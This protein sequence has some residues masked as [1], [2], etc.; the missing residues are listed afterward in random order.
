MKI[1]FRL[2]TA[3]TFLLIGACTNNAP[4]RDNAD[5]L[6]IPADAVLPDGGRYQGQILNGKFNGHGSIVWPNGEAYEGEFLNGQFSGKGRLIDASGAKYEGEFQRGVI[7]GSG[8]LEMKEGAIYSGQFKDNL[9]HGRGSLQFAADH[10][11]EGEFQNNLYHGK[12]ILVNPNVESY[13][14][15][16]KEGKY[17]GYGSVKYHNGDSYQGEFR[18]NLRQ[19][20][21][22]YRIA[23]G[24]IFEGDFKL[25]EF[26]GNGSFTDQ[27]GNHYPGNFQN[28]VFH[29][30]GIYTTVDGGI[31]E[32]DFKEGILTGQGTFK[33]TNGMVYEGEFDS[34]I[35][36][37]KGTLIKPNGDRYSGEFYGGM[38]HGIGEL[39][40]KS[41]K[42][43]VVRQIGEWRYNRFVPEENAIRK[44]I[45]E[46]VE[47]ALY[48]QYDLMQW[49]LSSLKPQRPQEIDLFFIG[50]A[51]YSDQE[52][53]EK[54]IDF[55]KRQF[56]TR[57]NT[58]GHSVALVNSISLE[59]KFPLATL[60]SIETTLKSVSEKM[61]PDNDILFLY[62]TS[63]GSKDHEFS[64]QQQG[65]ELAD[66]PA[67][68]LADMLAALPIKWKVV[69]VSACY[70]G[71][72]IAEIKDQYT[73]IMTAASH[74]RQSFGCSD[75]SDMTYF[76]RAYFEKSLPTA[77]SFTAAFD[78]AKE[79][80]SEWEKD[81]DSQSNPQIVAPQPIVA[82]LK[83]WRQQFGGNR[84][85][86]QMK[87]SN[88]P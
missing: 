25:G 67:N 76:G 72:V 21:G 77:E 45:A 56:D 48:H 7:S 74:D 64:I 8:V 66:L 19:G 37:G 6:M 80:I 57:Y 27:E 71:G 4:L 34:W 44:K 16:F 88:N 52:V 9:F 18:D 85:G 24:K 83:R 30:P 40:F 73:L 79:L 20:R 26:T 1:K 58:Q 75:D 29:G 32:G 84:L 43:D 69:V 68:R 86:S 28:W 15:S 46:S 42:A 36:N 53:F 35:F 81:L 33:G 10:Y 63:H 54:E 5:V 3:I 14:G 87:V 47:Y 82:Q 49:Q 78:D 22:E 12:G 51:G 70:A 50:I 13:D 2:P 55:I 31:F 59:N 38:K 11:Y 23:N 61:D 17:S 62:L 41:P 60:T 39:V 65:L